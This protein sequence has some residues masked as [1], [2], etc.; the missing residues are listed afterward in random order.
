MTPLLCPPRSFPRNVPPGRFQRA[1]ESLLQQDWQGWGLVRVDDAS[2]DK[3][4]GCTSYQHFYMEHMAPAHL[5][6]RVR[7][8]AVVAADTWLSNHQF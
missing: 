4:N 3:H 2:D 7:V 8:T 5:R 1:M 6:H